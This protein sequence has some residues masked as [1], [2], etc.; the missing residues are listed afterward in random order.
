MATAHIPPSALLSDAAEHRNMMYIQV[1]HRLQHLAWRAL[2]VLDKKNDKIVV[3]CIEVDSCW[4]GWAEHIM[5][6]HDWDSV[7][8]S[9]KHPVAH[10]TLTWEAC[11]FIAQEFPDLAKAALEVPPEGKVKAI[12]L[13]DGGCSIYELEPKPD[14]GQH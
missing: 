6:D 13:D 8:V 12:V 9:G 10:A 7:R 14:G 3:I 1:A 2:N 5:P 11:E 4:R